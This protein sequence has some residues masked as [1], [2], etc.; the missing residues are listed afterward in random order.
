MP[1][2]DAEDGLRYAIKDDGTA[3]T[4]EEFFELHKAYVQTRANSGP[5]SAKGRQPSCA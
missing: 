4:L 2:Y 3:A 1:Y 5:A